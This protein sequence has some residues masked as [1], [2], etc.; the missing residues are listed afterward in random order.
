MMGWQVNKYCW[1]EIPICSKT[2]KNDELLLVAIHLSFLCSCSDSHSDSKGT[3]LKHF[4][5]TK[6]EDVNV[7]ASDLRY[8]FCS[9]LAAGSTA[10]YNCWDLCL[11]GSGG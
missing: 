3:F 11:D 5:D 8:S 1:S 7:Y 4:C 10:N 2:D 6:F 9:E